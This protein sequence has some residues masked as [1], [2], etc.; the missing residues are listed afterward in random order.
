MP[1]PDL[2]ALQT[3]LQEAALPGVWSKGVNL[4]KESTFY[5]ESESATEV[6]LRY[7][8]PPVSPKVTLWPGEEDWHCDCGDRNDPC[9][10]AVAGFLVYR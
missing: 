6:L 2:S 8:K 9:V 1:K 3:S 7:H 4:S 5:L 10:H